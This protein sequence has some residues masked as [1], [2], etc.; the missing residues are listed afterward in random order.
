MSKFE[1][2][3]LKIKRA[4]RHIDELNRMF[5][6]FLKT[7]FWTITVENHPQTGVGKIAVT[8]IA[9]LPAE[10]PLIIGD[11]VHCLRVALDHAIAGILGER[12]NR[13]TFPVGKT[14]EDVKTHSTYRLIQKTSPDLAGVILETIKPYDTGQP[15]IWAVSKFDNLDKH[16]LLIPTV[17]V[18]T[19]SGVSLESKDKNVKVIDNRFILDAFGKYTI[20]RIAPGIEIEVT[21]KG[22][23]EAEILFASGQ[24]LEGQ[25]V[26]PALLKMAEA[27]SEAIKAIEDHLAY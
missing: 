8:S 24:P 17:T 9:D 23:A 4:Y 26:I 13:E 5:A 19:I 6:T 25:A 11:A 22:S 3:H 21:H 18:Q 7:D 12:G 14:R 15:S 2:S 27:S 1:G 16:R 20:G 10:V